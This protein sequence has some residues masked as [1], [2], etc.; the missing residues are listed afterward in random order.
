MHSVFVGHYSSGAFYPVGGSST[1]AKAIVPT[2][3]R[4]GGRVLVRARVDRILIENGKAAGVV[5][6]HH[7]EV[8]VTWRARFFECRSA[9][10]PHLCGILL[11]VCTLRNYARW[12]YTLLLR[13]PICRSTLSRRESHTRVQMQ[14]GHPPCTHPRTRTQH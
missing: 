2:I 13:I 8:W 11:I 14:A 9:K 7:D 4:A 1:I 12:Y 3:E 5:V 10:S 6:K